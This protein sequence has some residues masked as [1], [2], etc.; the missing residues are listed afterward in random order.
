MMEEREILVI[1]D[2]DDVREYL[3]SLLRRWGFK[4]R[5]GVNG[6]ECLR[7]VKESKPALIILDIFLPDIDG[8][9]V[10]QRL[11][12]DEETRDI[13]IIYLTGLITKEEKKEPQKMGR[14]Y[15]IAKPVLPGEL[16][17]TIQKAL[18]DLSLP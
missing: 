16:L 8:G 2:E 4:V 18:P 1:D 13:P 5:E 17:Q 14:H 9:E 11:E 15:I 6:E 10:A 3:S 7:L 12:E